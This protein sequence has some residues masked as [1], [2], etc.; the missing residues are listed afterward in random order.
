MHQL[1]H[2]P[3]LASQRPKHGVVRANV[4]LPF[5]G[6]ERWSLRGEKSA[7]HRVD[8]LKQGG[9]PGFECW[10]GY[11]GHPTKQCH[12]R[13]VLVGACGGT[14]ANIMF[15]DALVKQAVVAAAG[16][17]V[18]AVNGGTRLDFRWQLWISCE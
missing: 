2:V 9:R 15:D 17:L 18:E 5:P 3:A 7:K 11:S 14:Q 12:R 8:L 10:R 4:R 1:Q 13:V 6:L 16:T